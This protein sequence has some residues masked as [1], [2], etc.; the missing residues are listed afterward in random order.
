MK[1]S[2]LPSHPAKLFAL[3]LWAF[4]FILISQHSEEGVANKNA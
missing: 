3:D 4:N 2:R 1:D